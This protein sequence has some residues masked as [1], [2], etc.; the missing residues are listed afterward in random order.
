MILPFLNWWMLLQFHLMMS[1]EQT[2]NSVLLLLLLEIVEGLVLDLVL[3]SPISA[4]PTHMAQNVMYSVKRYQVTTPAA[5]LERCCAK[6][7]SESQ[8]VPSVKAIFSYRTATHVY[9]I[10]THKEYVMYSVS[11]EMIQQVTS[12]VTQMVIKCVFL[13]TQ[14]LVLTVLHVLETSESQTVLN[15]TQIF[16]DQTATR[17]YKITIHKEL[18]TCFVSLEMMQLVTSLVTQMVIKCVFP[19]TQTPVLTVLHVLETS[20]NRTV[21]NVTQIFRDQTATHAFLDTLVPTV[22][23]AL[24]TSKSQTV[25]NVMTIFKHQTAAHAYKITT[26]KEYV[27]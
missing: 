21:L 15:V 20:K 24:E 5:T 4:P 18:V 9:K 11:L 16:R 6:E 27:T 26:H 12:L 22:I 2:Q 19:D 14:T 25:L 8:T 1:K 7:T 3:V 17:A 10:T 13:D 23:H